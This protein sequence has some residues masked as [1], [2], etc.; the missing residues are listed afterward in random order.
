MILF[1]WV[2]PASAQL[3]LGLLSPDEGQ[4][5]RFIVQAT[6]GL[7]IV[8][9]LCN[10]IGCNLL[11]NLGDPGGQVF[12][13]STSQPSLLSFVLNLLGI[14]H[15]E[16]DR[17]LNLVSHPGSVIPSGTAT[18]PGLS[19]SSV[20]PYYGAPVWNGYISQPAAGIVRAAEARDTFGVNGA[21]V[22]GVIDTGV[23]PNHPALVPVL[24]PGYDFTRN[25]PGGSEMADLSQ[26]TVALVDGDAE[27][28]RVNGSTI[29]VLNQDTVALVDG[30]GGHQAF[31]HG[32][33]TA[34][35]VHLV[36]PASMILPLKAFS[37]NGTGYTSDI[38]RATYYAVNAG[39]KVLNMS[40]S[41]S[42]SSPTLENA[43]DFAASRGVVSIAAAGNSGENV[44]VYPAGYTGDVMGVGSTTLTDSRSSFSN[45]GNDVWVAAPGEGIISTYPTS[46]YAAG[47]GTSFSAPFVTGTV[48]LLLQLQPH[49]DEEDAA[50]AIGHAKQVGGNLGHGRLD[51]VRA[52]TA[53][54]QGE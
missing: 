36:S 43:L 37:A 9:N 44:T 4:P 25:Q 19:D 18:P 7:S 41:I 46:T 14:T 31:G 50:R 5:Q 16:P 26:D 1:S 32:T 40:F 21:G 35:I 53:A 24:L 6:G 13:F 27:P 29:A 49:D 10:L 54:T 20:V 12:A 48:G 2:T 3:G 28:V 34:G 51:V 17:L 52:L 15:V 22:I 47:W 23:D 42:S 11:L 45:Y 8:Q 38:I 39:V 30:G 33:M